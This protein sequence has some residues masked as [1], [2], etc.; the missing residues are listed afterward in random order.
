ML[1]LVT[2][3]VSIAVL[4]SV[5]LAAKLA[6]DYAILGIGLHPALACG[7]TFVLGLILGLYALSLCMIPSSRG[8]RT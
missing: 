2:A 4:V 5:V 8:S 6:T 1:H 3:C 7:A